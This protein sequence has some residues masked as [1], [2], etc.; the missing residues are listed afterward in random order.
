MCIF[1]HKH[2]MHTHIFRNSKET[3]MLIAGL[4]DWA[5][6]HYVINSSQKLLGWSIQTFSVNAVSRQVPFPGPCCSFIPSQVRG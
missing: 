6:V 4:V 2:D 5:A 3:N 1:T